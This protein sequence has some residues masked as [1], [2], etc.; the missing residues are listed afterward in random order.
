MSE[1]F[2]PY[3]DWDGINDEMAEDL[4]RALSSQLETRA[5][6]LREPT[7]ANA[8]RFLKATRKLSQ[9]GQAIESTIWTL[10]V[11]VHEAGEKKIETDEEDD[12]V[13]MQRCRRCGSIL[14]VWH[15]HIALMTPSGPQRIAEE[16]IPWWNPGAIIAKS[17][18]D[19]G[20][21]SM[22]EIEGRELDKH[23]KICPD[24]AALNE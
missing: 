16:D 20:M 12:E 24:L 1:S 10:P 21:M 13:V 15:E 14:Q 23:E 22:Y 17:D 8:G 5:N 3:F 19:N 2:E 11:I 9:I 6:F 4:H 18:S 7:R